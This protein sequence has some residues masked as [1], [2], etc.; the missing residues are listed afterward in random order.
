M[1]GVLRSL[2]VLVVAAVSWAYHY[3]PAYLAYNLNTNK[4]ASTPT[5]YWGQR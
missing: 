3:D 4:T 2:L 5:E 1:G